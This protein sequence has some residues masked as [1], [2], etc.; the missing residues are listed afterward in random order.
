[1]T[2]WQRLCGSVAALALVVGACGGGSEEADEDPTPEPTSTT[3][4]T[5]T[6]TVE[7]VQ[8][9]SGTAADLLDRR[10]LTFTVDDLG[11]VTATAPVP[12]VVGL[13]LDEAIVTLAEAGFATY[14][15][16]TFP[17]LDDMDR[18]V[19]MWPPPGLEFVQGVNVFIE[20]DGPLDAVPVEVGDELT[21]VVNGR[22]F[23]A[24]DRF[25][26]WLV[27]VWLDD[28]IAIEVE[29]DP[30]A[31]DGEGLEGPVTIGRE[32]ELR[33]PVDDIVCTSGV[34]V[35]DPVELEPGSVITFTL[36]A[37]P[38][39]EIAFRPPERLTA[40]AITVACD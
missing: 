4:P 1:M 17:P 10:D 19:D 34:V 15:V 8:I 29:P 2:R 18:V 20:L 31:L 26:N 5:P 24:F 13:E 25:E 39:D 40:A 7:R 38:L 14:R 21:G 22:Q 16:E 36:A 6:P 11:D 3:A 33:V 37:D 12:D 23:A 9:L 35:E 32:V 28:P 30:E 27:R